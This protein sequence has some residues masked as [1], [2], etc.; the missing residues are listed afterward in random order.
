MV[1]APRG[2]AQRTTPGLTKS[3]QGGFA[4]PVNI[5]ARSSW[6]AVEWQSWKSQ[7]ICLSAGRAGCRMTSAYHCTAA[8]FLALE[9]RSACRCSS[10]GTSWAGVEPS[11]RP[12]G[13]TKGQTQ[14]ETLKGPGKGR[15]F[16]ALPKRCRSWLTRYAPFA[17]RV[18]LLLWHITDGADQPSTT[19]SGKLTLC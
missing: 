19:P 5:C 14:A 8:H 15:S 12:S 7:F 2:G 10:A 11:M 16:P 18:C 3:F 6:E 1:L 17:F 9:G 4:L 13:F